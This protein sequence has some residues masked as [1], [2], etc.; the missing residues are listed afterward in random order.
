[1]R[2]E[3]INLWGNGEYRYPA[4]LG[5]QPSLHTS[6][7]PADEALAAMPKPQ[8]VEEAAAWPELADRWIR[9]NCLSG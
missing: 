2:Q 6:L 8:P 9:N 5:F 3:R 1:M 7:H 4:A